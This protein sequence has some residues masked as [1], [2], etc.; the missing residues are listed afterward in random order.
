MGNV[1]H[2]PGVQIISGLALGIDGAGQ[3]GALNGGE[4]LM[5]C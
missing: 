4:Q 2:Q 5:A 1:W 3:R